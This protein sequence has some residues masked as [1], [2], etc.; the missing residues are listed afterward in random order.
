VG[1]I[2]FGEELDQ[3]WAAVDPA[4]WTIG[5]ND[6]GQGYP[7]SDATRQWGIFMRDVAERISRADLP[8]R[9]FTLAPAVPIDA[10]RFNRLV[11]EWKRETILDSSVQRRAMHRAYQ[12]I[13]GLGRAA[14]P[15]IV[16]ELRHEPDYW[17]WALTAIT[18]EDPARD[19][20]TLQGARE[21]W[22]EW[23]RDHWL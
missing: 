6:W 12:Q 19:E 18:G 22:L 23:A 8:T 5:T 16:D 1:R 14:V 17:F 10:D 20:N 9:R 2:E 4:S 15:L 11:Q 21:R 13:I 3:E 7:E